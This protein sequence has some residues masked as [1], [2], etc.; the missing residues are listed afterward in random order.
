MISYS[1]PIPTYN[2]IP[3]NDCN[4]EKGKCTKEQF[5]NSQIFV[6]KCNE[7]NKDRNGNFCEM[8]LTTYDAI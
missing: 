3:D 6:C 1:N 5:K 8:K 2:C 4:K 7:N